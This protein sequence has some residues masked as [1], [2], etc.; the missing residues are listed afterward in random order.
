MPEKSVVKNGT[1]NLP[2]CIPALR[3]DWIMFSTSLWCEYDN[4]GDRTH[5]GIFSEIGSVVSDKN[6]GNVKSDIRIADLIK[7][8][9]SFFRVLLP[10]G[11]RNNKHLNA[12][13]IAVIK[14]I[15][16]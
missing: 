6:N 9:L 15:G 11:I 2:V 14:L 8:N 3:H 7:T 1:N 12:I 16:I 4:S 5:M 10:V 13:F